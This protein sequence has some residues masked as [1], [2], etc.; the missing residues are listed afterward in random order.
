ME[1]WGKAGNRYLQYMEKSGSIKCK[2]RNRKYHTIHNS[3]A[4]GYKFA[5]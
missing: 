4:K 2:N 5:E 1:E 3:K